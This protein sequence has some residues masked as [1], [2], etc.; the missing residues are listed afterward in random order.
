MF[1]FDG[2]DSAL[3]VNQLDRRDEPSRGLSGIETICRVAT[4]QSRGA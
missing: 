2:S 4:G 1:A 3:A